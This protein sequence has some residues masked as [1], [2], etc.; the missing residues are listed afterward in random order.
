MSHEAISAYDLPRRA[1]LYDANMAIMHPNREKMVDVALEVL[2]F[3]RNAALTALDLG[4]GTGYLARRFL[5]A[6]PRARL[7]AVDG[8]EEMFR[9]AQVRL[10]ALAERVRM[11]VGDF[12]QLTS[13]VA[14]VAGPDVVFSS[15][16]LHH[17]DAKDKRELLRQSHRLLPPGG[18]FLNADLIV[19]ADPRIEQRL[20]EIRVAG[21]V[22]RAAG[23]D[24]RFID[25]ATTRAYL[26]QLEAEDCDQPLTLAEDLE[27]ARQAGF[28][29]VEVF[30]R[31]YREVV[32]GGT[33]PSGP[34]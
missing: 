18:W 34:R 20:Q 15:F 8:S 27:L 16:A 23:R 21:I 2:P 26:D 1:A 5:E 11:I 32:Y 31:E 3:D 33:R 17:L 13:L 4:A 24:P 7:L 29:D 6:F 19:A 30:W 22:Q 25:A 10:G 12:R 14:G 28:S 9:L